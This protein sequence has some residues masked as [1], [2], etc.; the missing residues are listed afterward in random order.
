MKKMKGYAYFSWKTTVLCVKISLC[1]ENLETGC[2]KIQ[3]GDV[4]LKKKWMLLLLAAALLGCGG[5]RGQEEEPVPFP[6]EEETD[7]KEE[8]IQ[9]YPVEISGNLYDFQFAIDGEV[10]SLPSRIQEWIRQGWEYPEE[11]QKA[12]LETDSYIEGEV[13]K[14]GEK[15]LTVD[16]VNL[17]GKE[18]QVMDCYV[19]GI[20]LTYEKDGSVCQLPGGITLGKSSLIQVTEAYGTPTDEYSE[21]EELYVT[22]EFGTYKKAELVFDTE[23]EILQKAVLKNYREPVSEEEEISRET[24]EEVTAYETPQKL[25]ENPADY[26]VSYGRELY[27]IPAPVSEFVKNGWKIQEEGSDSYVKA[28]R[29]GYVTITIGKGITLG[30]TEENMKLLLDGIPLETQKEE[31][32]TSYYIYTDNTKKNFIRIFTDKDLGLIREIELSNSPEQL[33]AYTQQ[34]PESIP[35]SLPLGEGR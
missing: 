9:E 8:E 14:Q 12:M 18:T 32:G 1:R 28:G 24:P 35:E 33:T 5:C 23:E 16:L 21:K 22:Y 3:E 7:A 19:G 15:Q 30:M 31:Q 20:T 11:K 13:L 2:A 27:E 4:Y 29:H 26:I 10:K 6:K 17:E 25:T 34:A